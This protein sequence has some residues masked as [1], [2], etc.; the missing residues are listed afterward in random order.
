M[1]TL[2]RQDK[3]WLEGQVSGAVED[4]LDEYR[5]RIVE[6]ITR[7]VLCQLFTSGCASMTQFDTDQCGKLVIE[8]DLPDPESC[9]EFINKHF[10]EAYEIMG[11]YNNH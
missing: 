4:Y 6:D 7:G 1:T 2:I 11:K 5:D 9:E 3:D 10:S 8:I